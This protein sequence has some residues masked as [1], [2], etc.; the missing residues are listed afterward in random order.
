MIPTPDFLI[1]KDGVVK[2]SDKYEDTTTFHLKVLCDYGYRQTIINND[3]YYNSYTNRYGIVPPGKIRYTHTYQHA[4]AVTINIT[5]VEYNV[6]ACVNY[7]C[8]LPICK[9]FYYENKLEIFNLN[10]IICRHTIINT[11]YDQYFQQ[12]DGV[13]NYVVFTDEH[14]NV[15]SNSYVVFNDEHGNVLSNKQNDTTKQKYLER[16]KCESIKRINKYIQRGFRIDL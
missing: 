1:L 16:I 10:D 5:H 2:S 11:N 14:G 12:L 7:Y 3:I 13:N 8:D 4:N 9:N 6:H 15:L